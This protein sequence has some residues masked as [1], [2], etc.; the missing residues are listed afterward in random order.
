[1][2][3]W[4][5]LNRFSNL[6]GIATVCLTSY[7]AWR[8]QQQ[9]KRLREHAKQTT[10]RIENFKE[11]LGLYGGIKSSKPI[12]LAISLIPKAESIKHAV[13]TF[14]DFQGWKMDIEELNMD[15]INSD[16]DREHLINSLREKRRLFDALQVT[17]VHLF[18]AG[19]VQAGTLVGAMFDHWVPVK[20]Y[21]KPSPSPPQ[22]YEY[23]MPL[24]K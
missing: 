17:E 9:A 24:L 20:L 5:Y 11:L 2:L 18:I 4:E 1:M 19:P 3:F 8:V 23:W 6:V 16:E 10:P 7:I 12:A 13:Q 22:L 21:H 14:L 15:G